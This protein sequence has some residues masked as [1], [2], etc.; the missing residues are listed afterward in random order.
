MDTAKTS[1]PIAENQP[2]L[3]IGDAYQQAV[4]HLNAERYHEADQLCTAIIQTAP[5]H[6]DAINLLGVVAQRI[7]RHDLAVGMFQRAINVDASRV[8]LLYNLGISYHQLGRIDDAIQTL[9]LALEKDPGNSQVIEYLNIV[10]NKMEQT[11]QK[12]RSFQ[13]S[14]DLDQAIEWYQKTL[15]IKPDSTAALN[16]IGGIL[17]NQGRL[18]ESIAILEKVVNIEPNNPE[19]LNNLGCAMVEQGRVAQAVDLLK[20]ATTIKPDYLDALSNLGSALDKQGKPSEAFTCLNKVIAINPAFGDAYY[21]LGALMDKQGKAAESHAYYREAIRLN[22]DFPDGLSNLGDTLLGWDI[23]NEVVI[24]P[25]GKPHIRSKESI[26]VL[27]KLSQKEEELPDEAATRT[28][29]SLE[30]VLKEFARQKDG[31]NPDKDLRTLLIQPPIYKTA[32]PGE[33]PFPA[34]E[35]GPPTQNRDKIDGDSIITTYGLLSVAAQV[36][37]SGRKALVCNISDFTWPEVEKLIRYIDVDLV[38]ITCLTLNLRGV[39]AI[40]ELIREV[41]PHAHIAVGGSHPT[42]LPKEML[43]HYPAIDSV[44]IGEGELT[45]L[46]IIEKLESKQPVTGVAGTAWRGEDNRVEFADPRQRIDDLDS[47]ASPHDYFSLRILITSR[48]CPFRC[49]FCGSESQWG[50]KLKMN[51]VENI[52]QLIEQKVVID[53]AKFLAF[54]DDTFTASKKRILT[55]CKGIT[56]KKLNFVWSCDTRVNSLSEEVLRAMRMAGCQRISVGVESGSPTILETIKKKLVPE[57]VIEVSKIARKYGIQV[58]FY[59]IVGNRGE[60]LETFEESL[61]LIHDAQ[62]SEFVLINLTHLP[63]TEEFE[64]YKKEKNVTADLFFADDYYMNRYGFQDNL[65]GTTKEVIELWKACYKNCGFKQAG[66]DES[67][68]ALERLDDLPSAQ[69]DLAGAYIRAGDADKAEPYVVKA[70]ENGYPL[71]GYGLNYLACIAALRGDYD[72]LEVKLKNAMKSSTIPIIAENYNRYLAFIKSAGIEN[73]SSLKLLAHNNFPERL[74]KAQQPFHP[75]H[76]D[77]P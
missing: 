55:I 6:V 44:V 33:A 57:K 8:L 76:F 19:A 47:L 72:A 2:Q 1:Q 54:K 30:S 22:A 37:K 53:G 65:T 9:T 71:A 15:E 61:Q 26:D 5:N 34:A 25:P 10:N 49:T 39:A 28:Q 29:Y 31:A 21:N 67:L 51:S 40:S 27:S 58:R 17:K 3:T 4:D 24:P 46:E 74:G 7:N 23:S 77:I 64:I 12:A 56:E 20:K 63:G 32:P 38:G 42:A 62:P 18:D 70:M 60:T 75:V 50:S 36:L 68:A 59:M 73:G 52:L 69:M 48:G 45:F 14:G 11:F 43:Q 13:L 16:N 66:V 35:G 41:H